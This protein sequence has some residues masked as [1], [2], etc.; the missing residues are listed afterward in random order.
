MCGR[1]WIE[2]EDTAEELAQLLTGLESAMQ[3]KAPGFTLPRG[4][5]RPGDLAAVIAPNRQRVPAVFAMRW[6]FPM[7]KRLIIN[8]RS[9]TA[10]ARPM[11]SQSMKMR[12]C[13]IPA[14]A[15]FEWD[16]RETKPV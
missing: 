16:H 6:G 11:F 8:A 9:E 7:D 5:I 14:S 12:R 1:F 3:T 4:E 13:L 10:P 15:Y 2:P